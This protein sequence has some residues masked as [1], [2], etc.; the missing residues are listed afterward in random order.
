MIAI[1]VLN[2]CNYNSPYMIPPTFYHVICVEQSMETLQVEHHQK[3]DKMKKLQEMK[4]QQSDLAAKLE[5][6]ELEAKAE[7][8]KDTQKCTRFHSV[9]PYSDKPRTL[10]SH[11]LS[12]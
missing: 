5:C 12:R 6:D 7:L 2:I 9:Q 3:L 11:S 8:G 4:I 1:H 10:K